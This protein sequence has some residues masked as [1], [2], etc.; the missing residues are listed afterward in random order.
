[1]LRRAMDSL[2]VHLDSV[3]AVT[4]QHRAYL[5]PIHRLPDDTLLQIF[6]EDVTIDSISGK[7]NPR[8]LAAVCKRWRE[9]V[10]HTVPIFEPTSPSQLTFE[11]GVE[12]SLARRTYFVATSVSKPISCDP[13]RVLSR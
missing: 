8:R 4:L 10:T 7:C 1:M 6:V 13:A 5:V 9:F 12:A 3:T 2:Q 11:R